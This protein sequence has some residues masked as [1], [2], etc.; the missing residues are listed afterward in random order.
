MNATPHKLSVLIIFQTYSVMVSIPEGCRRYP[1]AHNLRRTTAG[2]SSSTIWNVRSGRPLD[3]AFPTGRNDVGFLSGPL[4]LTASSF[5]DWAGDLSNVPR[6]ITE[7]ALAHVIGDKAEQAYRRDD[8]FGE[9]PQVDGSM[10]LILRTKVLSV[11]CANASAYTA[12]NWVSVRR[13]HVT[14]FKLVGRR[15]LFDGIFLGQ[16]L[17]TLVE[18][19]S[20]FIRR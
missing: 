4:G 10:G 16:L 3:A 18:P 5:R 12:L 2:A 11:D 15:S 6:E 7:T 14:V 13:A 9:A 17:H 8:A 20:G 1:T 19:N